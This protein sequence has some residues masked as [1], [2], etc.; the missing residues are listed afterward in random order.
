MADD[1][2]A[3]LSAKNT[4][5]LRRGRLEVDGVGRRARVEHAAAP[6]VDEAGLRRAV[7]QDVEAHE[8][9]RVRLERHAVDVGADQGDH[10]R[11]AVAGRL[12]EVAR[13]ELYPLHGAERLVHRDARQHVELAARAG[14]RGV[15]G[16]PHAPGTA[17]VVLDEEAH[18]LPRARGEL[19][20]RVDRHGGGRRRGA[21]VDGAAA[22]VVAVVDQDAAR[23][24][25]AEEERAEDRQDGAT[26]EEA[27]E[28]GGGHGGSEG[29]G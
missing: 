11:R 3:T 18:A 14:D 15:A 5:H 8:R 25:G 28:V 4:S 26:G 19:D 13:L 7:E 22:V 23:G 21:R 12:Q 10:A 16:A 1:A 6:P 27:G 24:R 2:S 29:Q 17:G 20:A 9:A